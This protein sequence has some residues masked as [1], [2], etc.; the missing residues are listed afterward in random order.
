MMMRLCFS[1][2]SILAAWTPIAAL[3]ADQP[4][5]PATVR[6]LWAD[7]DPRKDALDAKVVRQWEKDGVVY[8]YVTYHIGTFKNK[9]ARMA[10]FFGFP[11]GAEKALPY[12]NSLLKCGLRKVPACA[13]G[14]ISD[15]YKLL[16]ETPYTQGS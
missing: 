6:E 16:A 11:K 1:I 8:R 2:A 14:G 12:S 7:F 10:A 3:A 5:S 13:L 15:A 4:R 9:P